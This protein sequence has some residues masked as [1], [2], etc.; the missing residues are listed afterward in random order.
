MNGRAKKIEGNPE[1]PLN[2]GKLCARGQ[3]SLQILYSPDRLQGAVRQ[4]QRGTRSYQS[5]SWEEALNTLYAKLDAA[6]SGL[7]IWGGAIMSGHLYQIFQQFSAAVGAPAPL[8][9]DLYTAY[10]GYQALDS[11][12]QTLLG[13]AGLPAYDLSQADVV[14]SF[15]ADLFGTWLSATRYG[16]EYG[17]FRRQTLGKRGYLVQFEPRMSIT[18]AKSDQWVPLRPGTEAQVAQAIA[19]IIADQSFGPSERVQRAKALAGTVDVNA[20]AQAS[21]VSVDVLTNL[22]RTF[23]TSDRVVAIP[24]SAL[25]GQ[26]GSDAAVTAVQMLNVIAGSVGQL[27]GVSLSAPAPDKPALG[28]PKPST[29]ADAQSLIAKMKNGEVKAL[30]VYGANPAYELPANSGFVDALRNV[31]FVVSFAPIVD[32]TAVW[33]DLIM[34]ERTALEAWG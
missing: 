31:P 20:V 12:G 27:G 16:I 32:E 5:I 34:H 10:H 33:A 13:K 7:A 6:G 14:F 3:S 30:L 9:F 29:Y 15:G 4:T 22:A 23:A 19:R 25:A 1:H 21:D 2:Q 11:T 24:G 17:N 8:I 26:P 18:G 28:Q